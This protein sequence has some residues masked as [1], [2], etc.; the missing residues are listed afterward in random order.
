MLSDVR[1]ALANTKWKCC[2]FFAGCVTFVSKVGENMP[3]FIKFYFI[4][5][6]HS[7]LD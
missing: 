5:A 2:G 1:F 4:A 6:V 7:Y 3:R